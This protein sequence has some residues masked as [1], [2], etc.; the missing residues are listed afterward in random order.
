MLAQSAQTSRANELSR[1]IAAEASWQIAAQ[2]MSSAMHGA[3]IF[4]SG[5]AKQAVAQ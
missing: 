3:I 5:S 4:T 1:A 2:S